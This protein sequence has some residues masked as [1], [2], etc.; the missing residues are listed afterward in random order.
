MSYALTAVLFYLTGSIPVAYLYMKYRRHLN[1]LKEGTGNSGAM[2]VYDVTK[3]KSDGLI[4]LLLD[5]LK[6]LIPSMLYLHVFNEDA[7]AFFIFAGLLILG[8]NFPVWTG[9]KG[10]RGLATA[11]GIML[12]ICPVLVALWLLVYFITRMIVNNV[13]FASSVALITLPI[14]FKS[15]YL[16]SEVF[17][18]SSLIGRSYDNI[19]DIFLITLSVCIAA[20][21]RHVLPVKEFLK[22]KNNLKTNE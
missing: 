12:A 3:S 10:G 17:A 13:H 18:P 15:D 22:S 9:F 8:H 7:S 4:V 21:T 2:N 14:F 6:G 19:D 20:M 11:A 1:I 5:L 16:C